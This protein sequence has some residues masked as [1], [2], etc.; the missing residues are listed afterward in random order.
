MKL[1]TFNLG[2]T[3]TKVALFEDLEKIYEGKVEHDPA[4]IANFSSVMDQ[5]DLRRDA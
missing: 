5:K 3:S 2:S 1:F 4:V